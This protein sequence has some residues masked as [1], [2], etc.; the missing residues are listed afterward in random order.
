MTMIHLNTFSDALLHV[1]GKKIFFG[2]KKRC[3]FLANGYGFGIGMCKLFQKKIRDRELSSLPLS[4][5]VMRWVSDIHSVFA[6]RSFIG[7]KKQSER[8]AQLGCNILFIYDSIA[9]PFAA[10]NSHRVYLSCSL[11]VTEILESC[12]LKTGECGSIAI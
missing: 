5:G 8:C 2:C 9:D 3:E 7:I 11:G 4:I 1:F 12:V 10:P 6:R